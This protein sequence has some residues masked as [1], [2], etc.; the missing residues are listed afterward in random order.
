MIVDEED[1]GGVDPLFFDDVGVELG[2]GLRP[3][4]DAGGVDSIKEVVVPF[5]LMVGIVGRFDV[6]GAHDPVAFSLELSIQAE[7]RLI[8][9]GG[10]VLAPERLA[11]VR[12]RHPRDGGEA[13]PELRFIDFVLAVSHQKLGEPWVHLGEAAVP[14]ES[15]ILEQPPFEAVVA[16][17]GHYAPHVA[18]DEFDRSVHSVMIEESGGC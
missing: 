17:Q 14:F 16:V 3:P 8:E 10:E 13:L 6:G 15:K 4:H 7:H 5:S 11:A 9:L 18:C 2:L 12:Y 1:L